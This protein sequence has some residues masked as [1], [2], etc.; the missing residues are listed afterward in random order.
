MSD[1]SSPEFSVLV[2]L[3]PFVFFFFWLALFQRD[4]APKIPRYK[5]ILGFA[6]AIPLCICLLVFGF[7]F[8]AESP[9][10]A[11]LPKPPIVEPAASQL[12]RPQVPQ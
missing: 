6:V 11:I 8:A 5:L 4:A 12:P 3:L 2:A 10:D 1:S 9:P 7:V